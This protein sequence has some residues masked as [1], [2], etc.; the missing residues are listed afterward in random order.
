MTTT[1]KGWRKATRSLQRLSSISTAMDGRNALSYLHHA[2]SRLTALA[3]RVYTRALSSSG[4]VPT[5]MSITLKQGRRKPSCSL[6][7]LS[8]LCTTTSGRNAHLLASRLKAII[9]VLA[10]CVYM[11]ARYSTHRYPVRYEIASRLRYA[12]C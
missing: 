9:A 1:R 3:T 8:I 6:Q 4:T 5:G 2:V 10:T 12:Y 7:W 11:Y